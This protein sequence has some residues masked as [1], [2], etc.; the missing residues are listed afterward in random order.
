VRNFLTID[1]EEWFHICGVGGA[2]AP[3]RWDALPSRVVSTTELILDLLDRRGVKA[4]FFVLGWIA[5]RHPTLIERIAGAGHEVASHGWSHRRVYEMVPTV[6]DEE[7]E[8]TRR[9]IEASGAPPPAGFRAPEWSITDRSLWALEVLARRGYRYDS[10][11]TPLR[12]VGNPNF[13]QIPH[14]RETPAGSL[15]EVP[16]AVR[17]CLGHNIPFGGGW[18][19]RMCRPAM[20]LG[21]IERR[22][23]RGEPVTIFV[24]PWEIDPDPPRVRLPL[25]LAFSHYYRLA[26]Y[27]ER[28]DDI[29]GGTPFGPIAGETEPAG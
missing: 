17:R 29:I 27:R 3:G 22:N 7:L 23:R 9:A 13:P 1:V 12:L 18:G 19:L 28:L 26:G 5:G 4:T 10:S 8:A 24:H 25:A 20:V 21:E 16:P 2:L 6:F 15:L 11:M 14:M